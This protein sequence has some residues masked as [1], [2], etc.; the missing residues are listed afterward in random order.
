MKS[1][2]RLLSLLIVFEMILSP[3]PHSDFGFVSKAFADDC[4]SGFNWDSTLNRCLTTEQVAQV[5][6]SVTNCNG[7]K[8]CY[9]TNAE[10]ALKES[11]EEGKLKA[12]LADKAGL[13]GS[14][15]KAAAVAVPLLLGVSMLTMKK[16]EGA[17]CPG[18]SLYLMMGAGVAAFAGDTIATKQHKSRLKKIQSEWDEIISSSTNSTNS[19]KASTTSTSTTTASTDTKVV[20]TEGQSQAFEM[21]ARNED[22]MAKAAKLKSMTYGVAT[23]AFAASAVMST[24]EA[25]HPATAAA[26]CKV[27]DETPGAANEAVKQASGES[28]VAKGAAGAAVQGALPSGGSGSDGNKDSSKP[29]RWENL[30]NGNVSSIDLKNLK[31][32]KDLASFMTLKQQIDSPSERFASASIADYETNLDLL[33]NSGIE[34]DPSVLSLV[35]TVAFQMYSNL[36]FFPSAHAQASAETATAAA[37][38]TSKVSKLGSFI[39][40]PIT[41]A[42]IA[43]VFAAWSGIMTL[44]AMKQAKI[45][46]ERAAYLR[47][48]KDDF[49]D[50][51]SAI[52]CTDAQRASPSVPSCYCYTSAGARNSE[53]ASSTVCTSLFTGKSVSAV[54]TNYLAGTTGS[55]IGCVTSTGSQDSNCACKSSNTC[56]TSTTSGITGLDTGSLSVLSSAVSPVTALGSGTLAEGSVSA[57]GSVSNAIRLLDSANKA[58]AKSAAGQEVAKAKSSLANDMAGSLSSSAAGMSGTSLGG[59]SLLPSNPAAAA[60]A[61]EK[62]LKQSSP[63]NTVGNQ[64]GITAP[65][66]A[67]VEQLDFG[68]NSDEAKAQQ[69]A[70]AEVMGQNLDYGQNDINQGSTTNI[71]EVLSNRY[72]RSGMRRLFD[73][74]GKTKADKPAL[75]DISK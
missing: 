66:N 45:A 28:I 73:E 12:Q 47:K 25:M 11:E 16:K 15:M 33:K 62:E 72:Q 56:L 37:T 42:I 29:K 60:L 39:S 7:D 13:M 61:L 46:K 63:I 8:A 69:G 2:A 41:R 30:I 64:N 52:G 53:R 71:F 43:G 22:S 74:T 68:T 57:A 31:E 67:A 50:A 35:K 44:H 51:S 3:L 18:I 21:L 34:K 17:S 65:S 9:K 55:E 36:E 40:K 10:N 49:N 4:P 19:T 54:E 26:K 75:N 24:L 48:M 14:G 27:K 58:A 38:N 6:N 5:M 20:A 59:S 32:A 23:V 1:L 70:I